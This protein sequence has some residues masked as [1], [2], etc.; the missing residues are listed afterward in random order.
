[1]KTEETTESI[2]SRIKDLIHELRLNNKNFGES[3][4]TS[5]SA[6][7]YL[8]KGGS[9]PSY[10][11]LVAILETYPQV[12]EKWL[13]RGEGP[14]FINGEPASAVKAKPQADYLQDFLSSLESKW[15]TEYGKIMDEKDAII[16][17][18]RF[19]IDTLLAGQK[20]QLGKLNVS[21]ELLH[22]KGGRIVSL[23][24]KIKKLAP[25]ANSFANTRRA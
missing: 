10:E 21:Q 7:G 13:M 12:S 15:K 22:V 1:M 18:Q 2:G 25:F 9:K 23:D 6:I 24:S 19:I 5:G 4:G 14:M 16:S 8:T 20:A 3:I 17:N 11:M